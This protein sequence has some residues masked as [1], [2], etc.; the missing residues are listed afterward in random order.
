MVGSLA[1]T[2]VGGVITWFAAERRARGAEQQLIVQ[3]LASIRTELL[4]GVNRI[5]SS[6]IS[7]Q[8]VI[9]SGQAPPVTDDLNLMYR[10]HAAVLHARLAP[11]DVL[12]VTAAYAW[13]MRYSRGGPISGGP[14][15]FASV[16]QLYI[17]AVAALYKAYMRI[18]EILE[19]TSGLRAAS[20]LAVFA[21]SADGIADA[22]ER[23]LK[24]LSRPDASAD[25]REKVQNI[26]AAAEW[27][28][29]D[30]RK[31]G[32]EETEFKASCART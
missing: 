6:I 14:R 30:L 3:A 25:E 26:K 22:C 24:A 15:R 16:F 9:Q 11:I 29:A 18:G 1:G 13:L 32:F 4:V 21:L 8:A 19:T 12:T 27:L 23:E 28:M 31:N 10:T 5:S 17:E 20:D 7:A 2:G